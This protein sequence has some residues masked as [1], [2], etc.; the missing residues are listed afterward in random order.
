MHPR[1]VY[2]KQTF[3]KGFSNSNLPLLLSV[4]VTLPLNA[5]LTLTIVPTQSSCFAL[6]Q[7]TF[8]IS[9]PTFRMSPLISTVFPSSTADNAPGSLSTAAL[10][11]ST[12][13]SCTSLYLPPPAKLL[14]SSRCFRKEPLAKNCCS[15]IQCRSIHHNS[16]H[17]PQLKTHETV[18]SS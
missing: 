13:M 7:R 15:S 12:A 2:I 5:V 18:I 4:S 11:G 14:N 1:L 3:G 8:R 10:S 16:T 9:P 6:S 17:A